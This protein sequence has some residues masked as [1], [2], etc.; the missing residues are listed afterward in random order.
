[1][2]LLL[3]LRKPQLSQT[4]DP[5]EL[6]ARLTEALPELDRDAVLRVSTRLDQLDRLREEAAELREVRTAVSAFARTYRDW[7]R[8]A[9]RERGGALAE[10]VN[11]S[12][13]RR[14]ALERTRAELEA[15]LE[16][17]TALATRQE[18]H[19][20]ELAAARAAERELRASDG[21]HAAERLEQLRREAEQAEKA[22]SAAA[23]E[24]ERAQADAAESLHLA[25]LAA[26]SLGRQQA[27]V[28][29]LLDAAAGSAAQ[30]GI[31][32]H[33]AAI[34]GLVEEGRE[35]EA[36]RS[37]LEQLAVDREQTIV[38]AAA[39]ARELQ[40]AQRAYEAA[41]ERFEEAET[42]QRERQTERAQA[43]ERLTLLR[44]NLL[45]R[46]E[47][48]LNELERLPVGDELGAESRRANRPRGRPGCA[49]ARGSRAIA[50]PR[51]SSSCTPRSRGLPL[52]VARSQPS[53]SRS[54]PSIAASRR[55]RA[56]CR[57]RS[58]SAPRRAPAGP[59]GRYGHWS[60]S[61]AG[62]LPSSR[63]DSRA[64]SK[65]PDCSTRG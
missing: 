16:Q 29:E 28:A 55:M 38:E 25:E 21:W 10:A 36:V 35:V 20:R 50:A 24:L 23:A 54:P 64:R 48:W 9:L 18:Q 43:D 44:E 17:R 57:S 45:E 60:T 52:L 2:R 31:T 13:K 56:R 7:A 58:R 1:M 63:P 39:L 19:D 12:Q 11:A 14:E 6:S 15:A 3:S 61:P 27:T 8:A 4:L 59:A 30:A 41:R 40:D 22:A 33:A 5:Q 32:T 37:L 65:A 34:A 62:S 46:L 42:R 51:P 26:A 47:A 49:A 53:G